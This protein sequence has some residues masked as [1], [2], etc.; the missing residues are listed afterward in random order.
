MR[1]ARTWD[2]LRTL[3]YNELFNDPDPSSPCQFCLD[4]I[5]ATLGY[6]F[7]EAQVPD[8]HRA[9]APDEDLAINP[10]PIADQIAWPLL[11]A[12]SLHQL[13]T[14]P[15]GAGMRGRCQTQD[16]AAAMFQNQQSIRS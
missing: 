9:K 16:F 4:C 2:W 12:I 5:I 14:Y 7:Q 10:V 13:A 15:F 3:R 1:P 8:P 11:P 6:D